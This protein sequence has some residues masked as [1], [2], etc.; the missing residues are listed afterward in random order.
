LGAV[1]LLVSALCVTS[2]NPSY[3]NLAILDFAGLPPWASTGE[4]RHAVGV[5]T[6]AGMPSVCPALRSYHRGR[7]GSLHSSR[8]CASL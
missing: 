8:W 4:S 6:D 1:S 2:D 5:S 3:I 7:R